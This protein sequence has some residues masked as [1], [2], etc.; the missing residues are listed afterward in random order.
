MAYELNKNDANKPHTFTWT[1]LNDDSRKSHFRKEFL[2]EFGGSFLPKN[3]GCVVWEGENKQQTAPVRIISVINP[4][5]IEVQVENFTK[6]CRENDLSRSAMYEVLKGK[7][8]QHK[9]FTAKGD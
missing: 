1:K 4:E 5:G 8:K 7:R 2:K 6:Y 9:G 3:D